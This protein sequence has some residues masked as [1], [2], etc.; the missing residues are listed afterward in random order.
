MIAPGSKVGP[1]EITAQLGAG[2][3]GEVFKARDSRLDR[4][5][6]I[7]VLP[8]RLSSDSRFRERFEREA[9][10][11]SSLSHPHIC[12]LYD[13]G[14][15]DGADFL[16]MEYLEGESLAERL[17]RGP[18]PIDQ[19][20]RYGTEIADALEKA[21]RMGIVHR[22]LKPG[23]VVITKSGAKLLD[24]GLAKI[25]QTGQSDPHAAT[26]AMTS[27][28][29]L[30][31]E[32]TVLGTFQYMAPEQIEGREADARTD[33]FAFGA[34]LY[35]MAT[36]KRAFEA[37]TRASLI[38]SILDREPPP[39]S[40]VQPLTPPALERVIRMCLH[41]DPDERWQSAHDV[42]AELKWIGTASAE[43]IGPGAKRRTRRSLMR[44]SVILLA[45]LALGALAVW[46]LTRRE[47]RP[48]RVAR[49]SIAAA[50][51]APLHLDLNSLLIS[52]DGNYVLYQTLSGNRSQ[53]YLRGIDSVTAVPV[54]GT[55]G[56]SISTFSPDGRWIAYVK[57]NAVWKVPREGGTPTK[58]ADV[59]GLG[60]DWQGDT[61]VLN[62]NFSGGLAAIPAGGGEP[63]LI[64][65]GDP[66]K[67]E[68]AV[69]W[70]EILPG[71]KYVLATAWSNEAWDSARIVAYPMAGGGPSK[72]L[73]Q[74]G[75]FAR[76][77]PTGHLLFMRG[78]N[79][80][81]VAFDPETLTVGGTP[82]PIING[83][84]YGTGDGE[85]HF[86]ISDAGHLIYATGG[87]MHPNHT[88]VWIDRDGKSSPIVPTP[89]RYGSV[90]IS[91]DLRTAAVT[92]EEST[93]DIWQLD[94]ER[95]S[96]T[97]VSHGGDDNEAVWSADGNRL[98]WAS[99]RSGS[100]NLYWRDVDNR[101]PE[102]RIVPSDKHQFAPHMTPDG[103]YLLYAQDEKTMDIW[104]APVDTRKPEP[105][106]ATG[107]EEFGPVVSPDGRWLAY[108]SDQ[109]GRPEVF[110]TSF[111][112][113]SGNW[114]VSINGG[115][116]PRWMPDGRE[117]VYEKDDKYFVVPVDTSGTRP[118]PGKP[119]V[120]FEGR[121]DNEYSIARD[122]RIA[123]I[124]QG[125]QPSATQFT[126]VM[127]WAEELKRRVPR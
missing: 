71:G 96:L 14:S 37:K 7:K 3:M 82:I 56:A 79:L 30:T 113:P 34:L 52:P 72:V 101:S 53:L 50:P 107:F 78:G 49:F 127:N 75:H 100:Y 91:P 124:H 55:D 6:A 4:T 5:V 118:R 70:P 81:A 21:H 36:G 51:N 65:R 69:V 114:P 25:S 15:H 29:P 90:D 85:G 24:F 86:A 66:A 102:E 61:I 98:I 41:K 11:I 20:I 97:R 126:F 93:Y 9:K 92:I 88:L 105:L 74:G 42:A 27:A 95:D 2:G 40:M 110:I 31:E 106:I 121:Y 58:L 120:L 18:L 32:G 23:N 122:G 8:A 45:G 125:E 38:A 76:Y 17:A 104:Q 67:K 94:I 43:T 99:S 1:Y 59:R 73:V 12:T 47:P 117:I 80:M 77:S 83:V 115:G 46:L 64:V 19:V 44:G 108:A 13:V 57:D 119:R 48:P 62:R 33:I 63:R 10:A 103:K 54:A 16:V 84:A 68:Q 60:L 26:A 123:I 35:E 87:D 111:P 116:S 28:K 39:I 112:K 22:D 89:R 109:S